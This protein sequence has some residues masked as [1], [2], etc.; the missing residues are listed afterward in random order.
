MTVWTHF[1]LALYYILTYFTHQKLLQ[2]LLAS[3]W[4]TITER[5]LKEGGLNK[6]GHKLLT[7]QIFNSL[8]PL[9][10]LVRWLSKQQTLAGGYRST[11]VGSIYIS[12]FLFLR[13]VFHDLCSVM[14][15]GHRSVF[16]WHTC[17]LVLQVQLKCVKQWCLFSE[18]ILLLQK[19]I[20]RPCWGQFYLETIFFLLDSGTGGHMNLTRTKGCVGC[21]TGW[22]VNTPTQTVQRRSYLVPH[23][24]SSITQRTP[25]VFKRRRRRTWRISCSWAPLG[26][27]GVPENKRIQL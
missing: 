10:P 14:S 25:A 24:G 18:I 27:V 12:N 9:I 5:L 8:S 22:G 15:M 1:T 2:A 20:H 13:D 4:R 21:N 16:V 11:Q 19:I 23:D 6:K 17:L 3:R 26:H 7:G